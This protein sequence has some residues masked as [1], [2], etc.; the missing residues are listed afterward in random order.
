MYPLELSVKDKKYLL[1]R[2]DDNSVS[3]IRLANLRINCPCAVCAEERG[4]KGG[5]YI[6]I[7]NDK[8]VDIENLVVV[9]TYALNVVWKDG[10]KAGIYE[11]GLLK[12]LSE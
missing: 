12:K 5:E 9:G 8:E 11:F 6:P 7:Y 4:K 2:W 3:R 10:H 1:V